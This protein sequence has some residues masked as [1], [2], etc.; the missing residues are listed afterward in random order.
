MVRG[1]FWCY[2]RVCLLGVKELCLETS[3][4]Y[5]RFWPDWSSVSFPIQSSPLGAR[6]RTST[7]LPLRTSPSRPA[8]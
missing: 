3:V 4:F 8:L 1:T 5:T 2:A 7:V 6:H